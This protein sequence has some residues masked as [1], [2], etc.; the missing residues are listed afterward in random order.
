MIWIDL[1]MIWLWFDHPLSSFCHPGN[2]G[3]SQGYNSTRT[4]Y[5]VLDSNFW[6]FSTSSGGTSASAKERNT[7]HTEIHIYINILDIFKNYCGIRGIRSLW[8]WHAVL[9]DSL[10]EV[11]DC[12][13]VSSIGCNWDGVQHPRVPEVLQINKQS[14]HIKAHKECHKTPEGQNI[15]RG[16]LLAS[17]MASR[18]W[19]S[20]LMFIASFLR[21]A[22]QLSSWNDR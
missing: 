20:S 2:P 18:S 12:Q 3:T 11:V 7:I 1:I 21:N 14:K 17:L 9:T 5:S 22:E 19:A 6:A 13:M 16:A 10:F 8:L 15:L 4:C